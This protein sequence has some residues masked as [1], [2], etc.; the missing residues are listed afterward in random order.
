MTDSKIATIDAL[1]ATSCSRLLNAAA[2]IDQMRR[3][4]QAGQLDAYWA[5]AV[6]LGE[7]LQ[8]GGHALVEANGLLLGPRPAPAQAQD[9]VAIQEEPRWIQ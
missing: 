3:Y 6:I 7:H 8:I 4:A 9:V 2:L 1:L 5:T